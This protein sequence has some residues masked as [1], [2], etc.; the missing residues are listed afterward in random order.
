MENSKENSPYSMAE[1][2]SNE[3]EEESSLQSVDFFDSE[4]DKTIT[5]TD[6]STTAQA[7]SS[8]MQRK[9]REQEKANTQAEGAWTNKASIN[10]EVSDG[11]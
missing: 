3:E 7:F 2:D 11:N 10:V 8:R 4:E 5:D 9:I 1:D 6:L